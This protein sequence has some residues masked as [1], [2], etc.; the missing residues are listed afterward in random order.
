M[1]RYGDMKV[2]SFLTALVPALFLPHPA[3]GQAPRTAE[4]DVAES[5]ALAQQHFEAGYQLAQRG[6][7]EAAAG[8][9]A[10]AYEL[11]PNSS[12]LYNLGH[13][14]AAS[15]QPVAAH[16]AFR[17]YLR[18]SAGHI[19]AERK[20]Q[21]QQFMEIA[22]GHIGTLWLDVKPEK[23]SIEVDG[24]F[25]GIAPLSSSVR[26]KIGTHALVARHPGYETEIVNVTVTPRGESR[27]SIQLE[28]PPLQLE[29]GYVMLQCGLP[30]L[31]LWVSNRRVG[32]TPIDKPL[33]L[34][35]G[36]HTVV[37]QRP[38]Y[39][40]PPITLN[41]QSGAAQ[42]LTCEGQIDPALPA[43]SAA[44]IV[45]DRIHDLG[46]AQIYVDG[47]PLMQPGTKLPSGRHQVEVR[48]PRFETWTEEIELAP[49]SVWHLNPTLLPTQEYARESII[50][51]D[52]QV[53]WSKIAL[54]T[55]V[56]LGL[57][58]LSLAAVNSSKHEQW[59]EERESLRGELV[60]SDESTSRLRANY[61]E[62]LEIQRIEHATMASGILGATSLGLA[63]LLWMTADKVPPQQPRA[64]ANKHGGMI[65]YLGQF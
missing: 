29:P 13:A 53:F 1:K 45:G 20:R 6:D 25:L 31:E 57:T 49:G 52:R 5:L 33:A 23:A 34:P 47:R 35:P 37:L 26:L 51:R 8:E 62:A 64:T 43:R 60:A 41:M 46:G 39:V 38:G 16:D 3:M 32:K 55:G 44:L 59:K 28:P 21:V 22:D 58:A 36:Q 10:R 24:H 4:A 30:D 17:N 56:V 14:Y 42:L 48:A 65:Q 40:F 63:A 11:S 50:R 27:L 9:F 12:V 7:Y 54:G 15:G 18:L 2:M 61:E 19:D